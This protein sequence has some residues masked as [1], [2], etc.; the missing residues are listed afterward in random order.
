MVRTVV[1]T[2]LIFSTLLSQS[3]CCCTL[4]HAPAPVA[5]QKA[6]EACPASRR[7]CCC[8]HHER[9]GE[10]QHPAADQSKRPQPP[11]RRPCPCREQKTRLV[12]WLPAE[13]Q[14]QPTSP[15]LADSLP[16]PLA[17]AGSDFVCAAPACP[18]RSVLPFM[19]AQDLLHALHMLRC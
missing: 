11:D 2:Y 5:P 7:S 17:T 16:A 10:D 12:A 9:P 4:L 14:A 6:G 18:Q 3:L 13:S 19:T 15:G 1:S 8:C